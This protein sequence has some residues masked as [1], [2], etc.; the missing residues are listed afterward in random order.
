MILTD[1][2]IKIIE[3]EIRRHSQ[4]E[5]LIKSLYKFKG[6]EIIKFLLS[7]KHILNKMPRSIIE[8]SI[9]EL[10][11]NFKTVLSTCSVSDLKLLEELISCCV[12]SGDIHTLSRKA[13]LNTTLRPE[14]L[15]TKFPNFFTDIVLLNYSP[16]PLDEKY[17]LKLKNLLPNI[18]TGFFILQPVTKKLMKTIL[19]TNDIEGLEHFFKAL[20]ISLSE[21]KGKIEKNALK[22]CI[23]KT[24]LKQ[25]LLKYDFSLLEQFK[26]YKLIK[27]DTEIFIDFIKTQPVPNFFI[28]HMIKSD[29]LHHYLAHNKH[30]SDETIINFYKSKKDI[31]WLYVNSKINISEH[32]EYA[33]YLKNIGSSEII[34]YNIQTNNE[35]QNRISNL[36]TLESYNID[37]NVLYKAFL[38]KA[39]ELE[40]GIHMEPRH[41]EFE[42]ESNV[43]Q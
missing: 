12:D 28:K 42:I 37:K 33:N 23:H 24:A 38:N 8:N 9:D 14:L 36:R 20:S 30:C 29:L 19:K 22:Y 40:I 27:N 11:Q 15:N 1:I 6:Q 34:E 10:K 39:V 41:D 5:Y 18:N 21:G 16:V 17:I 43:T 3:N 2:N 7:E 13:M 32:I 35:Q 4:D 25:I 26:I 31:N